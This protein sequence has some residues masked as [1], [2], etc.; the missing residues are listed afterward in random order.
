MAFVADSPDTTKSPGVFVEVAGG[1]TVGDE[2]Y[3]MYLSFSGN[4]INLCDADDHANKVPWEFLEK[5]EITQKQLNV[6]LN[7]GY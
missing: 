5:I 2:R 7:F 3:G 6:F 4:T 1:G